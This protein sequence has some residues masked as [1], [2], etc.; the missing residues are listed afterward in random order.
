MNS[1][2]QGMYKKP[3][4]TSKVDTSGYHSNPSPSCSGRQSDTEQGSLF[5]IDRT[6]DKSKEKSTSIYGSCP[7]SPSGNS[8]ENTQRRKPQLN[9][10]DKLNKKSSKSASV[11]VLCPGSPARGSRGGTPTRTRPSGKKEGTTPL[12]GQDKE[13]VILNV[14]A[15]ASGNDEPTKDGD[16]KR[17]D[18]VKS[19]HINDHSETRSRP[20]HDVIDL[21]EKPLN[22]SKNKNAKEVRVSV[23]TTSKKVQLY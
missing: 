17:V 5:M 23:E 12:T 3:S 20:Q 1:F 10:S 6:G 22:K 18:P 7:G 9:E 21:T 14:I 16:Q 11:S 13:E 19:S 8:T 15:A 2:L 4:D